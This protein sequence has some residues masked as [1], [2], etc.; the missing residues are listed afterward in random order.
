[1]VKVGIELVVG[2]DRG[3]YITPSTQST[4]QFSIGLLRFAITTHSLRNHYSLSLLPIYR[5]ALVV[6]TPV[7]NKGRERKGR[8]ARLLLLLVL[9]HRGINPK[10]IPLTIIEVHHQS[11]VALRL[12]LAAFLA[13]RLHNLLHG[14]LQIKNV[15]IQLHRPH[16]LDMAPFRNMHDA[17]ADRELLVW[18]GEEG[19]FVFGVDFGVG[20]GVVAGGAECPGEGVA[21]KGF[22]YLGSVERREGTGEK[23][24]EGEGE[25]PRATSDSDMG[26][27]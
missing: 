4:C 17:A 6:H 5:V 1:M 16:P 9:L 15:D 23:G 27:G 14:L 19:V 8:H 11:K 26:G 13:P 3:F 2:I 10:P 21:V 25:V 7:T 22:R 20:V 12:N 24:E 18:E